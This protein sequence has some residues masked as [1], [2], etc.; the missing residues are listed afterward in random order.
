MKTS[1]ISSNPKIMGEKAVIGVWSCQ[2]VE[3]LHCMKDKRGSDS[4]AR[5]NPS[6]NLMN[7]L[8]NTIVGDSHCREPLFW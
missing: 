6:K 4:A 5:A 7:V 8:E 2:T 1:V 3:K